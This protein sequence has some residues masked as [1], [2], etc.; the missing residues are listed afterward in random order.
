MIGLVGVLW[1]SPV[2]L[3][4]CAVVIGAQVSMNTRSEVQLQVGVPTVSFQ[5]PRVGNGVGIVT[6]SCPV[7]SSA[8]ARLTAGRSWRDSLAVNTGGVA[9][10]LGEQGL[11]LSRKD[12]EVQGFIVFI[13]GI[14]PGWPPMPAPSQ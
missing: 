11:G 8:A 13:Y 10:E 4:L 5:I 3:C 14:V 9:L 12:G 6:C 7:G 2:A 1:L